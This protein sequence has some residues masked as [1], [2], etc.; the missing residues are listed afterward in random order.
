ML[1]QRYKWRSLEHRK[2]TTN[3]V[4]I[5]RCYKKEMVVESWKDELNW[6]K[7]MGYD[8]PMGSNTCTSVLSCECFCVFCKASEDKCAWDLSVQGRYNKGLTF[9]S[10]WIC[11][12]V[13]GFCNTFPGCLSQ[14]SGL[15][16]TLCEWLYL[17]IFLQFKFDF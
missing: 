16:L 6:S 12:P 2:H 3:F 9:Q 11:I 4:D 15:Q 10:S 5:G 14:W 7:K 13:F 8:F 1:L 17:H